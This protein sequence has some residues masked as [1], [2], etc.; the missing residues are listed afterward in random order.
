MSERLVRMM[1]A[2]KRVLPVGDFRNWDEIESW[3]REIAAA[4]ASKAAPAI[5]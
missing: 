3:G 5:A 1:P 4:L 2:F